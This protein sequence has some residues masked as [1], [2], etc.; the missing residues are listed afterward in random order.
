MRAQGGGGWQW[1]LEAALHPVQGHMSLLLL[2][3]RLVGNSFIGCGFLKSRVF[4]F[5]G[6]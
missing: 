1:K 6:V 4:K 5:E 2:D 3:T